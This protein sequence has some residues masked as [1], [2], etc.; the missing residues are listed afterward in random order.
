MTDEPKADD[1][2]SA[3]PEG[4]AA[5]APEGDAQTAPEVPAPSEP[6]GGSPLLAAAV[7]LP[8]TFLYGITGVWAVT[9]AA[10]AASQGL[11]RLDAGY[12]RFVTP[13]SLAFVGAL[14]LA[15]FAVLL[16]SG[17]LL[18]FRRRSAAVWLPLTLVAFGLTAGAV[19]AG[20]RG[21]LHPLLWLFLFFG[22]V[23]VTI[24]GCVRVLQVTRAER[25]DTIEPS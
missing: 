10:K 9:L 8:W 2:L 16:A 11:K 20:I 17:L 25:R 3:A 14:L 4:E 12:T 15:A 19:W 24:V 21:G 13:L 1:E 22:L 23:Y 7:T 6:S 5:P 18:L